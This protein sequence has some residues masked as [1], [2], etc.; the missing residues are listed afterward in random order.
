MKL[1]WKTRILLSG[2][3]AVILVFA[4][5]SPT[6]AGDEE[7][8]A[9]IEFFETHIRPVLANN[10]YKCHSHQNGKSEGGLQLDYRDLLLKGGNSGPAL[11]PNDPENSLIIQA[12]HPDHEEL[13]MPPE[14]EGERLTSEQIDNLAAWIAM[15]APDP[16][17]PEEGVTFEA[18]TIWDRAGTHWSF[19]PVTKPE[20]PSV[21]DESWGRTPIDAFVLAKLEEN[22]KV[23][24][25]DADRLT[26]LRRA[27]FDLIGLPPTPQETATFMEDAD[28]E[29]LERLV[30]RLLDS[31]RYGER[32]GRHWLDVARYADTKGYVFEEERRYQ[33]AYTYRDY[34]I[35]AFNEDIPY[36][37]FLKHQLAADL[38]DLGEDK[39]P[40]AAMGFITLGRRFLNNKHDIIDDR[41]DVVTRGLMGLTVSCARCH[42]HKSD[43]IPTA[44]YY[45]FYGVFDSS[46]EP[47]EKP[48][49]GMEEENQAQVEYQEEKERRQSA[50]QHFRAT[51][52][53]EY[54]ARLREESG[55]YLFATFLAQAA[56]ED[57]DLER[58]AREKEVDRR[59]LQRWLDYLKEQEKEEHNAVFAPWFTF[60]TLPEGTFAEEAQA[61]L[62]KWRNDEGAPATTINPLVLEALAGKPPIS[63]EAVA[64]RY[65]G[66]FREVDNGEDERGSDLAKAAAEVRKVLYAEDAP[67]RLSGNELR[68]LFD[69]PTGQ[70]LRRLQR[71]I[72]QLD[73]T[74]PGAPPRAMALYDNA[75]PTDARIFRRG[76][77]QMQGDTVPRQFLEILEGEDRKPFT[78]GSGR[79]EMARAIASPDNPLT[80]RVM[81]NRVWMHHFGHGLVRT[82]SDFGLEGEAPT[83]PEL[84]DYLAA[85]FIESGWSIKALHRLIMRSSVYRQNSIGDPR[86]LVADPENTL[87]WKMNRRRL[88]FE[89]MRDSLLAVS[90]AL[91]LTK[92]GHAVE[93]AKEPFTP[94]RTVYGFIDRQNLPSLFRTF[95]FASP[96][97]SLPM[98]FTT[99]VPQQALF[100]MNNPF[101]IQQ[102][103]NL[104]GRP[105][106][107]ARETPEERVEE[108]Y[109]FVY[110]RDPSSEELALALD[111]LQNQPPSEPPAPD[112][113]AWR[114]GYGE[115]DPEAQQI[116]TF[117]TLP[118]F[119]GNA[120]QGGPDLP[121]AATGWV[122]LN[123]GG[124]HVGNDQQ[125][126]AIRRWT[127]PADGFVRIR[128]RIGHGNAQGDGIRARI[129]STGSGLLGEW[130]LFNNTKSVDLEEIDV[131]AGET[132]DFVADGRSNPNHDSFQWAPVIEMTAS[133]ANRTGEYARK[134]SWSAQT[135]FSGPQEPV[136]ALEPWEQYA[137][138]LLL[139]NE[140]F[141]VD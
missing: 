62:N 38:L 96:D 59:V 89:A 121:D 27:T 124:G 45:S 9:K 100:L 14:D 2:I 131:R 5:P 76:N 74:H 130:I 68:R 31:F 116:K 34:V 13:N 33:Y 15:G 95:D 87:L 110:Q 120:W 6:L 23:P 103:R 81:A 64:E 55:K 114:Y 115:Y 98:R 22:E 1:R 65:G 107:D 83:H 113:Q 122:T 37:E 117:H 12:V 82:P 67:A 132:I 18:T 42:D 139:S 79:L 4:L 118:H 46:H 84:L 30:D 48:L 135:D 17:T 123:P 99:T 16:R 138:V 127:A 39:S 47:D 133:P 52:E 77:P 75:E 35:R 109:K 8:P 51:K 72:D 85:Y 54:L 29:S 43:P 88:D 21:S 73:A 7:D 3:L 119:T 36:N 86:Y 136:L 25:T 97:A 57:D 104:I 58:L 140:F 80:A 28:E 26:L 108:L 32:W 24:A 50:L 137:Q 134:R 125:H 60:A 126:A 90:G 92:G 70:E 53:E 111:F 63:M 66:L 128:G 94:R 78:E 112:E 71:E 141:F 41:I 19:Q 20:V 69:I 10:C 93:I 129:I 91:D 101:I 49:L 40:L 56:Q 105:E 61:L 11:I 44:D 102:A 106:V